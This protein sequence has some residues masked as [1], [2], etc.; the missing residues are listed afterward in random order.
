MFPMAT[1]TINRNSGEKILDCHWHDEWEFLLVTAGKA[2]F[3]I[4]ASYY[5]VHSG[6]AVFINGG[7]IHA[8]YPQ[9]N[10]SCTYCAIVFDPILFCS[11]SFD[12]LQTKF[13]D[14]LIKGQY[15]LPEF[16]SGNCEWEKTVIQYFLKIL[17]TCMDGQQAFELVVKAELLLTLSEFV[18][19]NTFPIDSKSYLTSYKSNQMKKILSYIH[20]NYNKKIKT[21]N[22]CEQISMSE[23]YFCRFFK[24]MMR[25]TTVEYINRYRINIATNLLHETDQ[26]I[27]E[28]ALGVGFDNLSYFH[29]IF[30]KY[31]NCTPLE[32][33]NKNKVFLN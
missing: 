31:M 12:V 4:E 28:V 14:P 1:Y 17:N 23:G 20:S 11:S 26:K 29:S 5:E 10:S 2:I 25:Q 8:G 6:Q 33:R 27:L 18:K 15:V 21:K 3:Q 22:L 32:Y 30:K 19:N 7:N 24:Q 9:Q 13:I 16:I